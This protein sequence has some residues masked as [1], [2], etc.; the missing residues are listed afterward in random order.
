M[1]IYAIINS[2]KYPVSLYSYRLNNVAA[3]TKISHY[4]NCVILTEDTIAISDTI[5]F[6]SDDILI[7]TDPINEVIVNDYK[8]TIRSDKTINTPITK[9]NIIA[10]LFYYSS[11]QMRVPLNF[12]LIPLDTISTF[13]GDFAISTV[14]HYDIYSEVALG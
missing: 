11:T 6:Y 10:D 9:E 8:I 2:I 3:D 14:V 5:N 7:Y 13:V 1:N 12:D 4:L